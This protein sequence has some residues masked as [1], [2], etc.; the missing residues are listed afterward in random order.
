MGK[1]SENERTKRVGIFFKT[2]DTAKR[3]DYIKDY[4]NEKYEERLKEKFD[5]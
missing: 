1:K 2:E 5:L 4:V 3:A